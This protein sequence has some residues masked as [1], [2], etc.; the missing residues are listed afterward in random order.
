MEKKE[1][2]YKDV[3]AAIKT[4]VRFNFSMSFFV[5]VRKNGYIFD[6]AFLYDMGDFSKVR[7]RPFASVILEPESE[8]L[9]EYRNAY[10]DDFMDADKYPMSLK[11][12]YSVPSAKSAKEQGEL[13]G[14][15]NELYTAIRELAWKE[16]LEEHE[17]KVV[18]EYYSC[19]CRAVPNALLPFYEALSPEFFVWL[20]KAVEEV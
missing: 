20:D 7:L 10:L 11:I 3:T 2:R 6:T 9:L 1:K 16:G 15:V 5:P 8:V 17:K 14:K 12:D 18:R 19:F 4:A 13:V